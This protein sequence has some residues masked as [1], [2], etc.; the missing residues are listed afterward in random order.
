MEADVVFTDVNDMEDRRATVRYG[1][2][3]SDG[4]IKANRLEP[5]GE[6]SP[7]GNVMYGRPRCCKGKT[8]LNRR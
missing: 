8:D 4:V 7:S 3:R 2:E 1:M 5:P 6:R